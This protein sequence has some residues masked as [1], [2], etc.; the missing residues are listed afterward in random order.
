M[1]RMDSVEVGVGYYV[2]IG[3]R[4]QNGQNQATCDVGTRDRERAEMTIAQE[5]SILTSSNR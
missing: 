5:V 3:E 1:Q 4:Q 2:I